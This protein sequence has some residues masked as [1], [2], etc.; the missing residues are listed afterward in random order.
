VEKLNKD[1]WHIPEVLAPFTKAQRQDFGAGSMVI[2]VDPDYM[3][4]ED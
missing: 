4:H 2:E 3:G 1:A